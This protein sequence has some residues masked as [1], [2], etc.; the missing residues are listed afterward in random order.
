MGLAIF[1]DTKKARSN[2]WLSVSPYIAGI[3]ILLIIPLGA[4]SYLEGVITR[5]LIFMIFAMSYNFLM[6]YL[7]LTSLGHAAFFGVGAYT[8]GFLILHYSIESFWLVA[9]AA[10]L[11][12]ALTAAI[13]GFVALRVSEVYFVIITLGLGQMVFSI[14]W[15]WRSMTGGDSGLAGIPRPD[16]GLSS[17]TW[18]STYF[19]YFVVVAVIICFFLVYRIINSPFGRSLVGIRQNKARMG[20]L[21]YNTWMHEYITFIISGAFAGIAGMLLAYHNGIVV[22]KDAGVDTT[23]LVL[24]MV[25]I[26]SPGRLIAPV[27]GAPIIL[28]LQHFT[29]LYSPERWPIILGAIFLLS[30]AVFRGGLGIYL[31]KFWEK[32]KKHYAIVEG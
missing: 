24:L 29:S 22:P 21:G 30:V 15:K 1:R 12:A 20:T 31:I 2:R 5:V 4:S 9:P 13:F 19:Y 26:G 23:F 32:V 10:I 25:I 28:L 14:A 8:T 11:M 17:F 6:G 16:I 3:L 7:G 27:I 18:T